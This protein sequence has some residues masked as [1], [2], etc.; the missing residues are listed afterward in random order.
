MPIFEMDKSAKEKYNCYYID[1]TSKELY[2]YNR[3]EKALQMSVSAKLYIGQF[4]FIVL[5]K[6]SYLVGQLV[7]NRV[8]CFDPNENSETVQLLREMEFVHY[9]IDVNIGK[10][11]SDSSWSAQCCLYMIEKGWGGLKKQMEPLVCG[12]SEKNE[13]L[14]RQWSCI[15]RKWPFKGGV[16]EEKC[17]SS[18][19]KKERKR[20]RNQ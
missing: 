18:M 11:I 17:L 7:G 5:H 10:F 15:T 1:E 19:L 12:Q 13:W 2:K 8:Q 14:L 4:P 20:R 16:Y 9:A 3:D 6:K